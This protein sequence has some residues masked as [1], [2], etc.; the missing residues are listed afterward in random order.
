[1]VRMR[2]RVRSPV[3]APELNPTIFYQD[4]C[5]QS[6]ALPNDLSHFHSLREFV[7]GGSSR[8]FFGGRFFWRGGRPFS[9]FHPVLKRLLSIRVSVRSTRRGYVQDEPFAPRQTSSR[10]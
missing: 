3:L 5:E 7:E 10:T 9:R 8:R 2:S 6:E 1:M 4:F